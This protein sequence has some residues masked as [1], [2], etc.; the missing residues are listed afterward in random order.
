MWRVFTTRGQHSSTSHDRRRL[1]KRLTCQQLGNF[2][3]SIVLILTGH[4]GVHSDE[5]ANQ[6]YKRDAKT[7]VDKSRES[8]GEE[9][10]GRRR[11]R[12]PMSMKSDLVA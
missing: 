3:W 10:E 2:V 8:L 5:E 4:I 9:E 7:N 6:K 1:K 11:G 12:D